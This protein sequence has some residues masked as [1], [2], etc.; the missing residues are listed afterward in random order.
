L[1]VSYASSDANVA[2]LSGNSVTVVGAGLTTITASQD[3]NENYEAASSVQQVLEVNSAHETIFSENMG[4]PSTTT[5]IGSNTFQNSG[6]LTYS[7]GGATAAADVRITSAS[8]TYSG[9]SGNGNV[10]FSS[11]A[12]ER[13]FAIEGINTSNHQLLK[14]QFGYRKT[15]G[16][17]HAPLAI[18]YWNGSAWVA[19]ATTSDTAVLFNEAA[20][21]SVGWYLS[22]LISLP[23]AASRS[24]L[25]IRFIKSGSTEIRLDDVKLTGSPKFMPSITANPASSALTY[26]QSLS[27]ASLTGGSASVAGT[28][29]FTAPATVPNAGTYSA[30]VTFTPTDTANYKT[31]TINVNVTVNA[32]SLAGG[33]ITLTAGGDG[34][35][36]A[37]AAGGAATF[38]Y[39]Y[40]GRTTNGITTTYSSA[41]APTAAGYYTVAATATGNYSGSKSENYF[42]TG[43]VVGNDSATKPADNTRIKIPTATL[44]ANDNR[45]HTDGTSLTDN[46]SITAVANGTGTAAISGAFVLFTPSS[47]GTDNFTYTVTDSITGKTA[48]GTVTVTTEAAPPSFD[49]QIVG[50]GTASYNGTQ[51]SITM[52]FIGVPNQSYT[53]EYKGD[54]AE[55]S[56]TSAGAQSTGST[57]SFSVTFTKAG[58]HA[59]DWNGSMF[60]R[61]SVAP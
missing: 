6:S 32:A 24:G 45:I 49:L 55:A 22:K 23:E 48:T 27:Q 14:L 40:A 13:G 15:S 42:V 8:T 59:A 5:V 19:I 25:K 4:T 57:G 36:T 20:N 18:D 33:D 10:F 47:A 50:Q 1:T 52:D 56:W 29:T 38:S 31:L 9:A 11:S 3:G 21:A 44:L 39:S 12:G 35:Y 60:F 28:F 61:A 54:L 53:V 2:T 41:S 58:D 34:S 7:D 30:G 43:P 51:T 16:S 46:L 17:I 26:G 37:S